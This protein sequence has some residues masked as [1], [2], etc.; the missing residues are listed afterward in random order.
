MNEPAVSIIIPTYNR[1]RLLREA[2]DSVSRQTFRDFEVIVVDD[3]STENV[4]AVAA[5]HPTRPTVLRQQRKGPAAARNR[6]IQAAR[7]AILAFL[8][9]DDLW[10]PEKLERFI[11]ALN[12]APGV[13][14]FYGPMAPIT[15]DGRPVP[16]RSKPCRGGRITEHLF[17]SSFVHVPTVV[18]RKD[19]L[20]QAKCFDESLPVCEDYDLWLRL[21]VKETFGLIEEPLALRR[22]H[23]DRLSKACMSRN[24]AI[25]ATVLR[26]FYEATRAQG[27][28][29]PKVAET[30]LARVCFVAAR[31]ALWNGDYQRAAELCRASRHYG[32]NPVRTWPIAL[33]AAV[34]GCL[35]GKS[36]T[37]ADANM[38][39]TSK[40][41]GVA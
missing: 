22:L 20:L 3:G 26:R 11:A 19:V 7:G 5:D 32:Q 9:S 10:L 15:E 30:R 2:L 21:S 34:L 14:I 31:A 39:C 13:R 37:P 23:G 38:K 41:T 17:C 35:G 4:A 24:L 40:G 27:C 6:G 36:D 16:G 28:L 1:V 25:K 18:C 33:A 8:D 12:A 29:N